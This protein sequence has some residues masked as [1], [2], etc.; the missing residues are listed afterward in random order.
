MPYIGTLHPD[1]YETLAAIERAIA[2]GAVPTYKELMEARGI[3]AG[4]LKRHLNNLLAQGYVT[5]TPGTARSFKVLKPI[6]PPTYCGEINFRTGK[7]CSDLARSEQNPTF[8]MEGCLGVRLAHDEPDKG[9]KAGDILYLHSP[10]QFRSL[11]CEFH[12]RMWLGEQSDREVVKLQL[13]DLDRVVFD[14]VGV[15]R[16]CLLET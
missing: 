4:A 6:L 2:G 11:P 13:H 12:H 16:A 15:F 3:W 8:S 14:V 5:W 7:F 9:R 1:E 10:E